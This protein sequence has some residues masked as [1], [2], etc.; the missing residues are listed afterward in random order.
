MNAYLI[1]I[2]YFDCEWEQAIVVADSP[3]EAEVMGRK[4][5]NAPTKELDIELLD[6]NTKGVVRCFMS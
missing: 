3:E 4:A 6:L 1:S 5:L 2:C